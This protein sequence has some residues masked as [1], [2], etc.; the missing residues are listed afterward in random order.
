MIT[1]VRGLGTSLDKEDR[2]AL[3]ERNQVEVVSS[4]GQSRSLN[5]ASESRSMVSFHLFLIPTK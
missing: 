2:G 5:P 3:W 4:L 1:E